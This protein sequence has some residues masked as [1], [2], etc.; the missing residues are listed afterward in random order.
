[1]L[2]VWEL[3]KIDELRPMGRDW[4]LEIMRRVPLNQQ[5]RMLMIFWRVWHAHNELTHDKPCPSIEGSRRFLVSYLNSLLIIKQFPQ[6]DII[7]GKM[8][9]DHDRGF[10]TRS[11]DKHLV[12]RERH[13]WRPPEA[14]RA[15]L[16]VDGAYAERGR[17][18]CGMLLR[19][20]Q[21][22]V[23]FAA[24]RYLPQCQDATEAELTAIEEGLKLTLQ[25]SLLPFHVETD[26]AEA[27]HLISDKG[28]NISAYAFQITA[29]RELLR[30]RDCRITKI[31]REANVASHELARLARVN[32]H[33]EMS[34][35]D[36]PP[37]IAEALARDCNPVTV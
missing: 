17:A 25:W 16:N 7:K 37:D 30:E 24:C 34:L 18:G 32:E 13:G 11:R 4:L 28:P 1:L 29:I 23:I 22:D 26:C 27:L 2:E 10:K 15:T 6:E 35:G 3:P 14:L 36:Y 20:D 5:A 19:N 9:I 31:N 8:V 33:S 12:H 21:G